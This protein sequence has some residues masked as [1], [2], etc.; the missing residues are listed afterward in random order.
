MIM[1]STRATRT[2]WPGRSRCP[3]G[4]T[5]TTAVSD[6]QATLSH[7]RGMIEVEGGVGLIGF[8]FGGGL[9][10]H[11]AAVDDVDVLV[12]YYGSALR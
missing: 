10:F 3:S 12:S 11:V 5:G 6:V 9:A 7:L 8:C 2:C 4:S 1:I